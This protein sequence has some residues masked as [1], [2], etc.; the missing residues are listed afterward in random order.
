MSE[1][2]TTFVTRILDKWLPQILEG[3]AVA[4]PDDDEEMNWRLF[5]AHSQDMQGFAADIFTGGRN[6]RSGEC[7]KG[8]RDRWNGTSHA[9]IADLACMWAL[10]ESDF[11]KWSHPHKPRDLTAMGIGPLVDLFLTSRIP[12]AELF[13]VAI[14]EFKGGK[15]A[16]KT[17]RMLRAYV[18]NAAFLKPHGFSY[19]SYL[20]SVVPTSVPPKGNVLQAEARWVAA[21]DRD[22]YN[23]GDPL[24][25][26]MVCDWLLWFWIR[27]EIDWFAGFKADSVQRRSLA[28]MLDLPQTDSAF[29]QY[30]R[31]L[32]VPD[33]FGD[34]SG[35]PLPPR[36]LNEC[37]WLE[38]NR[39]TN[40][41]CRT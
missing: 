31:T 22:F 39:S 5:F 33:G 8:L 16:R 27:G 17:N 7:W 24:A 41:M 32:C 29:V 38:G 36:L 35:K 28:A 18:E 37:I 19:R 15:A 26:Y 1:I 40:P 2:A 10:H 34:L 9:L 21:V 3:E 13:G 25:N 6:E 14:R 4:V 23:V 30:C 12:G 20:R 11:K